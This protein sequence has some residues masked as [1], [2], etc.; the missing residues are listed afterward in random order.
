[1]M[2][3]SR[4]K[5]MA[6]MPKDEGMCHFHHIM[7][8]QVTGGGGG[9]GGGGIH[10]AITC[11][12]CLQ[13]LLMMIWPHFQAPSQLWLHT[14]QNTVYD[15]LQFGKSLRMRL[16]M[17]MYINGCHIETRC[18]NCYCIFTQKDFQWFINF[19]MW[20]LDLCIQVER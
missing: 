8:S 2:S 9:G 19:K 4:R 11:L 6:V 10:I 14:V 7:L 3:V 5:C 16:L 1:M 20:F 15:K 12:L 18:G 13:F 17:I